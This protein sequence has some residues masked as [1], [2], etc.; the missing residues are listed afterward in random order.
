MTEKEA[1][2]M[3]CDCGVDICQDDVEYATCTRDGKPVCAICHAVICS[4]CHD[5]HI[6]ICSSDF[7]R[8]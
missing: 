7:I 2:D 5:A 3:C 6:D 8:H 4:G 1:F